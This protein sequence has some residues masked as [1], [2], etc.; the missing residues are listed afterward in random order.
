MESGVLAKPVHL[1]WLAFLTHVGLKTVWGIRAELPAG[2]SQ[3]VRESL[4]TWQSL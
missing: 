3:G 1:E 4:G 2:T